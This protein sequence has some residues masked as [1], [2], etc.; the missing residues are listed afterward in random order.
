MAGAGYKSWVDGDI[1][2]AA[3]VNTYL[4]QQAVMRFADS[5]ARTSAIAA[6][7]EGMV[8]YLVDTDAIEYYDGAAWVG[9]NDADA[10]QNSI[11]D[12]KGD[13]IAATADN[14][15]ARLAVGTNGYVLTAD[16]A[17]AT[18]LKWAAIGGG[19]MST[20]ATG[21][22]TSGTSID[23]TSISSSYNQLE[24]WLYGVEC[25]SD[26]QMT[27]RINNDSG[28]NYKLYAGFGTSSVGSADS[29]SFWLGET[30][31]ST[32]GYTARISIPMYASG[33]SYRLVNAWLLGPHPTIGTSLT[34]GNGVMNLWYNTSAINRLTITSTQ[35]F[36]AGTYVLWG[37]T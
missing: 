11:V 2:T 36:T 26:F 10:I 16:S 20:L 3:D 15:P 5:A 27:G 6:P 29:T 25:A 1:L 33:T 17:E 30:V 22:L 9:I 28:T 31:N 8:S 19:G 18:G 35:T 32:G 4:M 21:S 12:A 7:S 37:I 23:L 13:L 24:L 34:N 14:T